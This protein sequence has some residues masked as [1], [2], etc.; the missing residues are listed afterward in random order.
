M[1]RHIGSVSLAIIACATFMSTK[2]NARTLTVTPVGTLQRN[3]G[4][5]IT[6]IFSFD[7]APF[8]AA[9]F[10][11][12]TEPKYDGTEL[13]L[14]L[15]ESFTVKENTLITNTIIVARRTF[16]VLTPVRDGKSDVFDATV[17]YRESSLS[18]TPLNPIVF[19]SLLGS[20]GDVV[21]VSEPP[22]YLWYSQSIRMCSYI[23]TKVF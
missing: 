16:D 10:M 9:R 17:T 14:R 21:P 6:F 13:S 5:S 3:P 12:F 4:D 19:T 23:Q 8:S 15:K 1:L 2:A 20:G 18:G 7:P 22:N 11:G